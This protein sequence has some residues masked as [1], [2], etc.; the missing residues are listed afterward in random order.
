[1]YRARFVASAKARPMMAKPAAILTS[2]VM[3]RFLP[4]RY[5]A[6]YREPRNSLQTARNSPVSLP[7]EQV[8][9]E[10]GDA[11]E[12]EQTV[13]VIDLMLQRARLEGVGGDL[14]LVPVGCAASHRH[15]GCSANVACEVGQAHAAFARDR[16]TLAGH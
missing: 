4:R 6:D 9:R 10:R 14:V 13:E 12:E 8:C 1:M 5:R 16:G 11:V 3:L 2:V 15:L 7:R